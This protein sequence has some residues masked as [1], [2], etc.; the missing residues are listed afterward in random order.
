MTRSTPC[1]TWEPSTPAPAPPWRTARAAGGATA[2]VAGRLETAF[3]DDRSLCSPAQSAW[4]ARRRPLRQSRPPVDRKAAKAAPEPRTRHHRPLQGGRWA[5][6]LRDPALLRAWRSLQ[7]TPREWQARR[8][9]EL[10]GLGA[11]V[12]RCRCGE[13]TT[14]EPTL[15]LGSS[16]PLPRGIL[17]RPCSARLGLRRLGPV[18]TATTTGGRGAAGRFR[19]GVPRL[20]KQPMA[21]RGRSSVRAAER[22]C[23]AARDSRR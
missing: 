18:R 3:S 10:S 7:R 6:S 19:P 2:S 12:R 13:A 20:R 14:Q 1:R 9:P 21:A 17:K 11:R 4:A 5:P 15:T 22:L 8:A 16:T 23:R